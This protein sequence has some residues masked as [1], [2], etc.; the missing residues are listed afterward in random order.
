MTATAR[1]GFS[2]AEPVRDGLSRADGQLRAARERFVA[3]RR[4]APSVRGLV[5]ESWQRCAGAGLPPDGSALPPVRM[6]RAELSEY[7]CRHPLAALLPMLRGLL[8]ESVAD[9]GH[10]FSVADADGTL[11]WVE[12]DAGS[13]R[14]AERMHFVEGAVWTEAQ[15]GT[16]APGTAL[17][18]GGPVQ[19]F[20]SEHYSS[21]VQ[22][23]SCAAAPIRDPGT[24]RVLGV[25]DLTGGR[26]IAA[27]AALAAVR[28]AARA[29]EAE[30]GRKHAA[31]AARTLQQYLDRLGATDAPVALLGPDGRV[32][33]AAPG[34]PSAALPTRPGLPPGPVVL[35]DGRLLTLEPL[36]PDGCLIV[37]Q[38]DTTP[39]SAAPPVPARLTALGRDCALLAADGRAHRLSRRHSE[40][41]VVLALAAG[42]MSGDRLGVELSERELHPSTVRAEMTRLRAL[43]GTALLG[44]RP[45]T[46]LREVRSDFEAVRDLLAEGRAGEALAAYAGPLLPSSEAP[47]VVEYRRALEQQLRGAVLACHDP[48]VLRRWVDSPWGA[49]DAVAWQTLARQLPGGSP[50]R[51]AVAARARGLDGEFA[52]PPYGRRTAALLQPHR[53]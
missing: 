52:A 4:A 47:A 27:P 48:A 19:I 32:L 41:V 8:G 17:A 34:F 36:G 13:L 28:A 10:L 14:R 16:N 9:D 20:G 1:P 29:A 44:S 49:D 3:T 46:L 35:P 31:S 24:G 7:R 23:W 33:H 22:P 43:L 37:R 39:R 40:I 26:S 51:G 53:S 18:V 15:A 12:G 11:L 21:A 25:V 6:A 42:G 2:Y 50:Q 5:A 38:L 45:Y 30:F